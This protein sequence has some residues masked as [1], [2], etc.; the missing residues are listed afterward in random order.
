MTTEESSPPL[1]STQFYAEHLFALLFNRLKPTA[2]DNKVSLVAAIRA[3]REIS[4]DESLLNSIK[5][6][7]CIDCAATQA[8]LDMR[9]QHFRRLVMHRIMQ[10]CKMKAYDNALSRQWLLHFVSIM[11][12]AL[13]G[14]RFEEAETTVNALVNDMKQ[15]GS[16]SFMRLFEHPTAMSEYMVIMTGMALFLENDPSHRIAWLVTSMESSPTTYQQHGLTIHEKDTTPA[17]THEQILLLLIALFEDV[18]AYGQEHDLFSTV[19]ARH[20]N[21]ARKPET[22]LTLLLEDLRALD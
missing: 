3:A 21:L 2:I 16:F 17:P 22:L 20:P 18:L 10:Q 15:S 19:I 13:G 1:Q 5:E 9:I 7:A 6:D 14:Y 4:Q 12:I 11:E 8:L